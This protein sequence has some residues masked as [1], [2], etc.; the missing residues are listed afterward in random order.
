MKNTV[1]KPLLAYGFLTTWEDPTHGF[2][3]GY[4]ILSEWGRPLEFHCSTPVLPNRAQRILYGATLRSY[5]LGELIGQTLLAKSKLPVEAVITDQQEMLTVPLLRDETVVY[6][7]RPDPD[8]P[9]SEEEFTSPSCT[10]GEYRITGTN[11]CTWRAE[12]L[13]AVLNRL[14][15]QVDLCEPFERIRGAIREAQRLT[16][17]PSEEQS[18]ASAAA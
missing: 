5:V 2:F 10:V 17:P 8:D 16:D 3:G 6:I 9:A 7:D 12:E 4:L 1:T 13:A 18:D 14:S 15:E 11:S